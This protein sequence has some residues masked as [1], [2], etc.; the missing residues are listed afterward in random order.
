MKRWIVRLGLRLRACAIA[1]SLYYAAKVRETPRDERAGL[2]RLR[3]WR[4]P[5][6]W[7]RGHQYGYGCSIEISPYRLEFC[8]CCGEEIG[9]R[10]S[11]ADIQPRPFDDYDSYDDYEE[12]VP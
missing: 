7:W 1:F 11:W 5:L 3:W 8:R 10:A 9:G 2:P 12:I 6:C 4:W